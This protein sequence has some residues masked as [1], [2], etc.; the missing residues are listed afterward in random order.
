M[1]RLSKVI[2]RQTDRQTDMHIS[3]CIHT[4]IQTDRHDRIYCTPCRFA[5]GQICQ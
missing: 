4:Y 1:S 3:T 2:D 5:C